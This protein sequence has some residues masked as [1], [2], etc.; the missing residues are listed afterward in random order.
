M[1]DWLVQYTAALQ[2][3][4][5]H[6][7]AHKSYVDAYTQ[8]A[9]K[10]ALAAHKPHSVPVTPTSTSTPSRGNP[11]A[12][13]ST[14]TSTDAVAGLRADLASTQKAR[15]TLAATL[16]DVEAQLAQLQTE[17]KES[18]A[19]IAT[20]SRAKLDSERKLRDRDAELKGKAALV[21]RTQD[22]M[23]SLEMQLNMAEEK[24]EK[25]SRENK[26]LVDRWMKRMGEE[27]EKINRDSK[28]A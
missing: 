2:N 5:A 27:A 4:D 24:A 6:E 28:W 17:R 13:G 11:V 12:R 26:D 14:P 22:E 3:R 21:G 8:L 20:L 16:K 19:Q 15:A 18:A 23:V 25:L 10:T 7:Q 9:D 1:S